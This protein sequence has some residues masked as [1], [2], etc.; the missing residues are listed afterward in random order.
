MMKTLV[1]KLQT[2]SLPS[3]LYAKNNLLKT[4]SFPF[5]RSQNT[6][7]FRSNCVAITLDRVMM[8]FAL[9]QKTHFI[10]VRP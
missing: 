1:L 9:L 10:T 4:L 2:M 3:K 6:S 8:I 5:Y 7:D